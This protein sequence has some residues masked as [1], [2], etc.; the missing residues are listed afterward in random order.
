M[1]NTFDP[2]YESPDHC[3]LFHKCRESVCKE[4]VYIVP[5]WDGSVPIVDG[6]LGWRFDSYVE[7]YL[8]KHDVYSCNNLPF[9]KH[10]HNI[11]K[12][13]EA[14]M[15]QVDKHS[16]EKKVSLIG[17]CYGGMVAQ[18]VAKKNPEKIESMVLAFSFDRMP[19][20]QDLLAKLDTTGEFTEHAMELFMESRIGGV[21]MDIFSDNENRETPSGMMEFFKYDNKEGVKEIEIP[22]YVFNCSSDILLGRFPE[23]KGAKSVIDPFCFHHRIRPDNVKAMADFINGKNRK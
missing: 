15:K 17:S 2:R 11:T 9:Y 10:N 13:A 7:K 18:E 23:I 12:I 21:F 6:N 22:T 20:Y 4:D 19:L 5:G 1:I 14:L 16:K 8:P 3:T